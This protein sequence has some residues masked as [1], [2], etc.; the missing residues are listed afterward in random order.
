M[1]F[2]NVYGYDL[3]TSTKLAE[4][5]LKYDLVLKRFQTFKLLKMYK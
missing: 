2:R 3:V 5:N 4:V 1:I